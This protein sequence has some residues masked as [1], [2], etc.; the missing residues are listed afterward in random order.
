M[1]REATQSNSLLFNNAV[2]SSLSSLDLQ[3]PH[4]L[5]SQR[6]PRSG[7]RC[8]AVRRAMYAMGGGHIMT[9]YDTCPGQLQMEFLLVPFS[10]KLLLLSPVLFFHLIVLEP[11]LFFHLLVLEVLEG[12]AYLADL[13]FC[14][15][16]VTGQPN[17][18]QKR[19]DI[20]HAVQDANYITYNFL[21]GHSVSVYPISWTALNGNSV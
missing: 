14:S 15:I 7:T 21:G 19:H 10:P 1:G 8:T 20:K 6:R 11:V 9:F 13:L 16:A 3:T 12:T 4:S 17:K 5:A 2:F 18:A